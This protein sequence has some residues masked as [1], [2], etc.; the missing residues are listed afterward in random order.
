[1]EFFEEKYLFKFQNTCDSRCYS[2]QATPENDLVIGKVRLLSIFS[3]KASIA[4]LAKI[5]CQLLNLF[6]VLKQL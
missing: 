1:M 2:N 4:D 3:M 6:S 5:R